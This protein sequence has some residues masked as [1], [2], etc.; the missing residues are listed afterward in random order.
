MFV[1]PLFG[2]TKKSVTVQEYLNYI[3]NPENEL[4]STQ[5]IA[6][7]KIQVQYRPIDY[8]VLNE[9]DLDLI[10]ADTFKTQISLNQGTQFFLLRIG[11]KDNNSDPLRIN[12]QNEDQ[13]Q[14]RISYLISSVKDDV[15][16]IDGKDTL[17][18]KMHHYERSYHL[19]NF[20]NILLLFDNPVEQNVE[21][22]DKTIIF[23]ERMLETGILKFKISHNAIQSIP[24]ILI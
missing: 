2:C 21:I 11:T 15:K 13:Y 5:E 18:C 17:N 4:I 12:L 24:A 8:Q 14:Q 7:L 22:K 19:S 20:H 1:L 23:N 6:Q 16:L 9:L 3:N 10:N